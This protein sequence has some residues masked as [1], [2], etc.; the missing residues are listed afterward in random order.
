MFKTLDVLLNKEIDLFEER[1]I[2]IS[3]SVVAKLNE[4]L[5]VTIV[6]DDKSIT[7]SLDVINSS[8]KKPTTSEEIINKLSKLGNT[9]FKIDKIDIDMDDDIFIPMHTKTGIRIHGCL[10]FHQTIWKV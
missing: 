6:C 8:I 7:R 5:L 4:P 10:F 9:P 3:F 1:K 2:P